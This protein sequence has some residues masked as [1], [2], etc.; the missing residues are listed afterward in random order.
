MNYRLFALLLLVLPAHAESLTI[1]AFNVEN[2]FDATH[3]P[4]KSD[5]TY[6]PAS[7]KKSRSHIDKC[8]KV[9]VKRWREQCLN[10][11]WNEEIVGT[12][13]KV[14]G[15]AIKQVNDGQG[16]DIIALQEV[17]NIGILERLRTEQLASLGYQTSVLLEGKDSRGIDVAF[18]SKLKVLD[19]A[20]H[21][22]VFSA[23]VRDR[24]GDTRPILSATFELPNGE[25]I[26]GYSVHFPAPYHPTVMRESAFQTLNK[27]L[28]DIPAGQA[29]FA[30]GDFNTTSE[31]DMKKDVLARWVRP[32]WQIAHDLCE[33]CKGTSYYSPA[34]N[35]SFLDMVLWRSGPE[36][37]MTKT[38]LANDTPD[39]VT[40]Y[41]K[42]DGTPNRFHL[43]DATGVSDH[44]PL[45]LKVKRLK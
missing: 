3:D 18:L 8:N 34:D 9:K 19:A 6:L 29:A 36:W 7:E 42:P 11:D 24:V 2:L 38:F 20:H 37:T 15:D 14:I 4:G 31:E 30:A 21:E 22:I 33:G 27:L 17:E 25:R 39:Q 35:W 40:T 41:F 13:L 32:Y 26:T 43:P 5:E 16:P 44:W 10:W 1:M 12:K 28:G 45:V 23:S